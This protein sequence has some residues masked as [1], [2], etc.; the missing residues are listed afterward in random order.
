MFTVRWP[1]HKRTWMPIYYDSAL[2]TY[3]ETTVDWEDHNDKQFPSLRYVLSTDKKR[4]S[5]LNISSV[6]EKIFSTF[7]PDDSSASVAAWILKLKRI[8]L[9]NFIQDEINIFA[10]FNGNQHVQSLIG[11]VKDTSS[12]NENEIS[13]FRNIQNHVT[14]FVV[15]AFQRHPVFSI[16]HHEVNSSINYRLGITEE[17]EMAVRHQFRQQY[18]LRPNHYFFVVLKNLEFTRNTNN[19]LV[20]DGQRDR[21]SGRQAIHENPILARCVVSAPF[22]FDRGQSHSVS[23]AQPAHINRLHIE[24]LDEGGLQRFQTN[25]QEIS[26]TFSFVQQLRP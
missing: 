15:S 8:C 10:T 22:I 25:K 14:N 19:V 1:C 7:P 23:L 26:F 3:K 4:P 12:N 6:P 17:Y 16:H 21:V 24:L 18:D 2:T 13:T 20:T 9:S 11:F 5:Q